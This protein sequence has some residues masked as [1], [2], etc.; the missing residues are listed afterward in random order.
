LALL[1]RIRGQLTLAN[2]TLYRAAF[3]VDDPHRPALD[4][5]NIAFLEKQ[6]SPGH[7]QQRRDIRSDEVLLDTKSDHNRTTLA[8]NDHALRILFTHHG[9]GISAFQLRHGR[10]HALEQI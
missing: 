7:G 4:L 6:E 9:K 8:R 5:G 2:R 10:A 1:S 3:L